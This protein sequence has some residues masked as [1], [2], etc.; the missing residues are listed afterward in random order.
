MEFALPYLLLISL[1]GL[2]AYVYESDIEDKWRHCINAVC[3]IVVVF[4]FGFRGFCFYDWNSYFPAFQSFNSAELSQLPIYK[5]RFEPGFTLFMAL[6]KGVCDNYHFFVFVCT[7]LNTWLLMRFFLRR[8]TNIPLA[9]TVCICMYGFMLMTDLMRNSISIL[10]F[11]NA[12]PYLQQRRPLPYFS[13]ILLAFTFHISAVIYLPFYFCLHRRWSKWVIVGVFLAGNAVYL[14]HIPVFLS[15]ASI[16]L[17]IISP[18]LAWKVHEYTDLMANEEFRLSIGYLERLLTGVLVM[19]YI[20]RLREVRRDGDLFINS[21]LLYFAMFFFFSEFK[22]VSLR[23][24]LL[25]AYAYWII[26]IDLIRCFALQ[27][28]R[29]LFVAFLSIYCLFK[30]YGST[31]NII[32]KYDNLLFGIEPYHLRVLTY[33]K[34]FN[35][36]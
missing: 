30:I 20:D 4:F 35:E 29:R 32:C 22:T 26:W 15:I 21:I 16:F 34:N 1:L 9:F 23:M 2:L 33:D 36:V 5:W 6:C 24:S 13:L 27:N 3:V 18:G 31:N 8:V 12:L 11:I 25:F 17:D 19:L 28:N 14:L 7:C 10:I